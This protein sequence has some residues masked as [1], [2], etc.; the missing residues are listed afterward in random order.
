[1]LSGSPLSNI[2]RYSILIFFAEFFQAF[3]NIADTFIVG[4]FLGMEALAA[5]G[6]TRSL[7]V[8]VFGFAI[9]LCNGTTIILAQRFGENFCVIN[10][11]VR[12]SAATCLFIIT[13]FAILLTIIL[14]PLIKPVL[15]LMNTPLEIYTM[16]VDY[17]SIIFYF[18]CVTFFA[19]ILNSF[20]Y[21]IG[22]SRVPFIILIIS[23]LL[24]IILDI[25]FISIFKM[26]VKGAASATV[27]AQAVNLLLVFVYIYKRHRELLPFSFAHSVPSVFSV[28]YLKE[29]LK[30]HL[31]LGLTM[32]LQQ[33][34]I[35]A[36]NILVQAATNV[37]GTVAVAAVATAQRI[38]QVNL[39][40]FFSLM[41]GV[42]TFTAQ[43]Y[44]AGQLTRVRQGM[45][46]ACVL[47][48][49]MALIMG[50]ANFIW[51]E[52]ASSLFIAGAGSSTDVVAFNTAREA[53]RLS[54]LYLRYVGASLFILAIMLN[55]RGATQGLGKKMAPTLCS[56]METAMSILTAFILIPA[57]GYE[58]AAMANPLSWLASAVPVIWNYAVWIR[59]KSFKKSHE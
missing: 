24:N 59:A 58:C 21:A 15:T 6:S 25:L 7:Y 41:R 27:I 22:N 57:F 44:G 4:R 43:N 54:G 16:A 34:I 47:G 46:A 20:L 48:I 5:V 49:A 35:E 13:V 42:T 33:S 17:V 1:M 56:I 45:K 29:E 19:N 10:E 39:M 3:Y 2:V 31:P 26:G 32:A 38:R 40:P 52:A 51:G 12:K 37:L 53:V 28:V 55:F 11:G 50:A 9:G 36:G 30:A 23:S 18:M 14:S 8:F